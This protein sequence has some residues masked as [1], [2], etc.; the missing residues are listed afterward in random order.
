[1]SDSKKQ[2]QPTTFQSVLQIALRATAV[3]VAYAGVTAA[4]IAACLIVDDKNREH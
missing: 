3:V 4:L 2:Q 1:M